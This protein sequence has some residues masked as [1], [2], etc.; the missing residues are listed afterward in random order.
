[1]SN[2]KQSI[3][4]FWSVFIGVTAAFVIALVLAGFF[5]WGESSVRCGIPTGFILAGA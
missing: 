3:E 5:A 1:M 2:C 4:M